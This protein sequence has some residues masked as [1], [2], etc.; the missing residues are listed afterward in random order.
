M[1]FETEKQVHAHAVPQLNGRDL[2]G[3]MDGQHVLYV[4]TL[5][6]TDHSH[7]AHVLAFPIQAEYVFSSVHDVVY[8]MVE[9]LQKGSTTWSSTP[10]RQRRELWTSAGGQRICSPSP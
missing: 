8:M 4:C 3:Y 1:F 9:M 10:Q 6:S 7:T 2:N 5:I